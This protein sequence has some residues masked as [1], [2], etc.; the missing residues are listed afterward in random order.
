MG[1]VGKEAPCYRGRR[2][3]EEGGRERTAQELARSIATTISGDMVNLVMV[4]VNARIERIEE[5]REA[6]E[7]RMRERDEQRR[8]DIQAHRNVTYR[9]LFPLVKKRRKRLGLAALGGGRIKKTQAKKTSASGRL[10]TTQ[11]Y[12][13]RS[14]KKKVL[15]KNKTATHARIFR[16]HGEI[17]CRICGARSVETNPFNTLI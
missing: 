6:E 8:R 3:E 15:L 2:P 9:Q 1:E 16:C 11:V 4:A 12:S 5:R 7:E 17:K 10:A 14:N 13:R